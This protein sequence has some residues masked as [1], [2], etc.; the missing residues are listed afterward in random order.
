MD[1]DYKHKQKNM[2]MHTQNVTI[3][4]VLNADK[5]R[6]K[7]DANVLSKPSWPFEFG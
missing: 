2:T 3:A 6:V 7:A 4:L 5:V 1:I